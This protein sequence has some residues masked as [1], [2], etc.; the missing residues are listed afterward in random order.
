MD[1]TMELLRRSDVFRGLSDEQLGRVLALGQQRQFGE[2]ETIVREDEQ[3]QTCF[4]LLGGRVDIEV[5]APFAGGAKGNAQRLA[6]IKRGEMF[7]ELSLVDGF[8]RSAS[9]R[10]ADAVDALSFDNAELG[11]LMENDPAIGYRIMH[12]IANVLSG[13]IR[14]TNMKLRNALSDI[15]YY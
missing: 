6:T 15:F 12:N 5:S 2:G 14:S 11:G 9:A 7:G 8:L 3:G 10:A 13:R 4:F 1:E